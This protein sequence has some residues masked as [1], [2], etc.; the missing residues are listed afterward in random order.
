M[1]NGGHPEQ[2]PKPDGKQPTDKP[3]QSSRDSK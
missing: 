1:A 3:T 2:K